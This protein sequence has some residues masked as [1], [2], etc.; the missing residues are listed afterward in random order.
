MKK[1]LIAIY[2]RHEDVKRAIDEL[3]KAGVSKE[4]ISALAKGEDTPEKSFELEKENE[5]ILFWGNQGAFWGA[6]FGLLAGGLFSIV[7]GFGP[8]V[9]AGP[10]I[11]SLA[12]LLGGAATVGSASAI[13]AW[14]ADLSVEKAEAIRY[15]DMLKNG[16]ILVIVHASPEEIEKAKERLVGLGV[17]QVNIH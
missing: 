9:A 8:L 1:S 2:E 11:S 13:A 4:H 6:L 10:V 7:P 5:A 15:E 3:I 17:G 14:L 12:G 16:K